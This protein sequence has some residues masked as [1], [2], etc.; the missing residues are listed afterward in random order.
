MALESMITNSSYKRIPP[1]SLN[2]LQSILEILNGPA[3][4]SAI[5]S[6]KPEYIE[7]QIDNYLVYGI[8]E[9][10]VGCCEIFQY[11]NSSA[12]EIASLAVVKSY[13]NQG[14]GSELVREG[15]KEMCP[16][17]IKLVFA[18]SKAVSHIFTQCGFKQI[19][20]EELPEEKLKN[21]EFQES[22]VYGH[23]TN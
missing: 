7:R 14:I 23:S 10:E 21:Y 5:V 19:S 3:H 4:Y 11:A 15:I 13:L 8:D 20:P 22:I 12:A 6:R 18:L 17:G 9:D 2:D 16:V 1:V